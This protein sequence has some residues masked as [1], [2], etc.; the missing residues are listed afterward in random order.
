MGFA[1]TLKLAAGVACIVA[2]K[3]VDTSHLSKGDLSGDTPGEIVMRRDV[4]SWSY[5][6]GATS[7]YASSVSIG[8]SG[9][10][11]KEFF[12]SNATLIGTANRIGYYANTASSKY[13]K[14]DGSSLSTIEVL[15]TIKH[16]IH[17]L[18]SI[19]ISLKGDTGVVNR[20]SVT[21]FD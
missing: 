2:G 9:E 1:N 3:L 8:L 14:Q 12:T 18:K 20:P 6:A 7:T 15:E 10:L 21:P 19:Q 5:K 4:D 16:S 13:R 17:Q 11:V